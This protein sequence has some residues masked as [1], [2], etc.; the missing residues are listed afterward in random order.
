VDYFCN[1]FKSLPAPKKMA[2]SVNLHILIPFR[3]RWD[4]TQLCLE[5]LAKQDVCQINCSVH[6]IDNGSNHSTKSDLR[7]WLSHQLSSQL[8]YSLHE[9]DEPFNFSKLCNLSLKISPDGMDLLL[10]LNNDV[11]L[12]NPESLQQAVS[13]ACQTPDCGAV[14]IT[15]LYPDQRIQHI[16]AAPGVK[17]VAAHP[18]KGRN[19]SL[20][21]AWSAFARQV[22]AV[23]GAFL[24]VSLEHFKKA[25]GFDENLP[26]VGQDIDLCLNLQKMGLRN[27][28]LPYIEA[29]H[30]ESASRQHARIDFG[31]VRYIYEK[32]QN[33]LT[34]NPEY[35]IDISR[36]SEQP[37]KIF[38]REGKYPYEKLYS[39]L[40]KQ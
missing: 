33:F 5:A 28:A 17:I 16:F 14:G 23:T 40:G 31:E 37:A 18:F 15:L 3:N 1:T 7:K 25:G 34:R 19:R 11:E 13:F 4:L 9:V 8:T 10:F 12:R 26:T 2:S 38:F 36:F 22:P 35:P 30:W 24:L 27:W 32:W 20:L 29:I 39:L 6:L 21:K